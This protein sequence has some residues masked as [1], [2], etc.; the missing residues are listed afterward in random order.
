MFKPRGIIPALVTP[1]DEQ[2]NL[3]EKSLRNI[4]DYTL[5]AG[6]HGVFVLGSTGEIYGLTDKEK[7]RVMEVTVEHVNGRVPVYAGAGEITTRQSIR[8]A[9]MAECVGGISALSVITPYFITPTQDEL[10]EHYKAIAKSVKT[11]IILYGCD[12]RAHNS[13]MPETAYALSKEENIIGIK[14]S[15]GSSERMDKYLEFTKDDEDFSVL[16]GIDTLIYH[17]LVNGTKGAIASSANIAPKIS[18]GIY[19]AF[20]SGDKEK[21]IEF[22][23]KLKPLRDAYALGTFPGLI[24]EAVNLVGID[25]GVALKPVG[26]ISNE[27]RE[28][29]IQVLKDLDVYNIK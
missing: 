2:G 24:K 10:I 6:V 4:I 15:S 27:N 19:N 8:T 14:D 7:Q 25:V 18:V 5:E 29:L 11:P 17:G 1:L 21:A 3:I 22:Q 16:C 23:N 26:T 12:G 13:I 20:M 9:Q 28:K